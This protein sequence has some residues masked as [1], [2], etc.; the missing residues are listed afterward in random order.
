[1][2]RA[3]DDR[4]PYSERRHRKT[5]AQRVRRHQL[6]RMK[7]E[8]KTRALIVFEEEEGDGEAETAEQ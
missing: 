4:K 3:L 5:E 2:L 8:E 6:A 7:R 1:M